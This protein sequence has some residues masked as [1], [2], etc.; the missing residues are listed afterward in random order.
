MPADP[1]PA[2]RS[3]RFLVLGVVA[4]L[5]AVLALL[6]ALLVPFGADSDEEP[7]AAPTTGPPPT[8]GPRATS[9]GAAGA[10]RIDDLGLDDLRLA[11]APCSTAPTV[12][13]IAAVITDDQG[14]AAARLRWREAAGATGGLDMVTGRGD[15]YTE[16]LGPF[17]TAGVVTW[18]IEA[19]D[20][21]GNA[22]RSPDRTAVVVDCA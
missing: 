6:A 21:E 18:W 8:T 13:S 11:R 1:R 5:V 20:R 7:P 14:V 22:G 10:P 2:D 19:T 15:A 9:G 4:A 17:T 12:V 3:R 16:R